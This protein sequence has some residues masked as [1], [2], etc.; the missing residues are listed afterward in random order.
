MAHY[1]NIVIGGGHNGLVCAAYLARAGQSVLVLEAASEVGGASRTREFAA[2]ARVSS[3]AHL[4]HAMPERLVGDLHLPAHG[5]RF[6]AQRLNT[7]SLNVNGQS[8]VFGGDKISG[9]TVSTED[10]EAYARFN[11]D[12][13][14]FA[15]TLHPVFDKLPPALALE[16]WSQRMELLGLGWT[17]RKLGRFSMRELLRIIGM[18]LYDLLD[19]Y[20]TSPQLK[21]AIAMDALLGSEWGARSM[22]SVMTYLYRVAGYETNRAMGLASPMG[23]MGALSDAIARA[24]IA[25]GA[26][27]RTGS[28]VNRILIEDDKA[29]GVE[30]D[31]GEQ[32][33]ANHVISNADPKT[34]FLSLVSADH[35]DTGF[36]RRIKNLRSKGRAAKLH[37]LLDAAP[38]FTGLNDAELGARLLIAPT[39]DAIE[40]A[41]NPCKY[42]LYPDAPVME[43]LVPSISDKSLAKAGQHVLSAVVQYLPYDE[44]PD[45]DQNRRA[46]LDTALA[47]LERYAPGIRAKV[48]KAELLTPRDIER[49]FGMSGGHWHH[50]EL[51]LESFLVNRPIPALSRHASP[52]AGL[53]LCGAGCHPGG[54]VMGIAGR[55]AARQVLRE[56]R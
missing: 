11:Q 14:R 55:N 8:I 50:V 39:P 54:N 44:S 1:G 34:T 51:V 43:I 4:L 30:L 26:E 16:T 13:R 36:V 9:S 18:N 3:A 12:M 20:F 21:A 27:I 24:A 25:A 56:G 31:D 22:G 32:I 37:L 48:V 15:G 7:V 35:L 47:E 38:V 42:G 49:E 28:R 52:I 53:Y 41:F 40:L 29:V 23:G 17:I 6:A 10:K 45:E 33:E 2:G 19:E 46:F 5:L